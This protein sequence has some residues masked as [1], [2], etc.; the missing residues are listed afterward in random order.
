MQNMHEFLKIQHGYVKNI[1][2]HF[3]LEAE[4]L[5]GTLLP[6]SKGFHTHYPLPLEVHELKSL[7]STI[8]PTQLL[9]YYPITTHPIH[10]HLFFFCSASSITTNILGPSLS[11]LPFIFLEH[12][13]YARL[14]AKSSSHKDK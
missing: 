2:R 1:H 12:L 4:R 5:L 8:P 10:S 14:C 6:A 13:L 7:K 3:V 11:F 9:V